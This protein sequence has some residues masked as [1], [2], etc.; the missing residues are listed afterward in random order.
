MRTQL[1]P[2]CARVAP[3]LNVLDTENGREGRIHVSLPG[4]RLKHGRRKEPEIG[5]KEPLLQAMS[6]LTRL[7][8]WSRNQ[9]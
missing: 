8:F 2:S 5:R 1:S 3:G 4:Q 6:P 7:P 9:E